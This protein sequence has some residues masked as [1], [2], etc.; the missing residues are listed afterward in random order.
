MDHQK[1]DFSW[2]I[3]SILQHTLS[4][5]RS[6]CNLFPAVK[7]FN[8]GKTFYLKALSKYRSSPSVSLKRFADGKEAKQLSGGVGVGVGC[9]KASYLISHDKQ[10]FLVGKMQDIFNTLLALDLTCEDS[11][12]CQAW[13]QWQWGLLEAC[14]SF[15]FRFCV[16]NTASREL[17]YSEC[18]PAGALR[19]IRFVCIGL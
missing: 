13:G 1:E 19:E 6:F 9:S 14:L 12:G 11:S 4:Q 17:V 15:V 18:Q 2:N 3:N 8:L 7:Q 5:E 10:V 16:L